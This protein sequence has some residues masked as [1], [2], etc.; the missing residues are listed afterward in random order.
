MENQLQTLNQSKSELVKIMP[1]N[2]EESWMVRSSIDL[3]ANVSLAVIREMDPHQTS[4]LVRKVGGTV[5]K[6]ECYKYIQ[7]SIVGISQFFGVHFSDYQ[8]LEIS[9]ILYQKFWYWRLLDWKNFKEKVCGLSYG[10]EH[11]KIFGFVNSGHIM[12]WAN[13]YDAEWTGSAE[14][15]TFSNHDKFKKA[16]EGQELV[17][18][19]EDRKKEESFHKF[20]ENY[21]RTK[22]KPYP[23]PTETFEPDT[24]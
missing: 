17:D 10:K 8:L 7:I 3:P 11:G 19:E 18:H 4:S 20:R 21:E 24:A 9:K 14:S 16:G 15:E 12:E 2:S 13:A 23:L 1:T 22:P 6:S 5:D